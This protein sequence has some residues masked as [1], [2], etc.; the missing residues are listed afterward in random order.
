MKVE[1]SILAFQISKK[2]KSKKHK[3]N[4]QFKIYIMPTDQSGYSLV[5]RHE[6]RW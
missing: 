3:Y 1:Y 5:V 6:D 2:L 4:S